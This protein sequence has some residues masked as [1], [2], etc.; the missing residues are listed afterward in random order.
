MGEGG[1]NFS[2]G[3]RQLLCLARALLRKSRILL[4]DEATS[5]IDYQTDSIIQKTIKSE[6]RQRGSTV[7]TIAHRLDT[8]L[9]SDRILVMDNGKV[10]EFASPKVL[11]AKKNSLLSL[12][13]KAERNEAQKQKK[14]QQQQ[15]TSSKK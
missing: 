5:S 14:Q 4:L 9:E 6:A 8:V 2:L 15:Q 11:L 7:I 13:V 12:L 1:G 10:A 3:Q